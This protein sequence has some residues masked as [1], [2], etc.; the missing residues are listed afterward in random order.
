MLP[1]TMRSSATAEG[2]RVAMCYVL[3]GIEVRKVFCQQ[4]WPSMSLK[5]I[6]TG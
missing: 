1:F 5:G 2:P 6:G 4:M 3:P